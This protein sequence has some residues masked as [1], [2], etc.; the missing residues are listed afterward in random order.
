LKSWQ[1]IH[2]CLLPAG[3]KG[4]ASKNV[5]TY[6]EETAEKAVEKSKTGKCNEKVRM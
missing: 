4:K 6:R 3:K 5:P 1:S 2:L